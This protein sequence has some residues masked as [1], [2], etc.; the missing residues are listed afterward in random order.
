MKNNKEG[1]LIVFEGLNGSG[2]STQV[3]LLSKR[4]KKEG[5]KVTSIRFPQYNK[6]FYGKLAARYLNGEFGDLYEVNPYL[7]SLTYALDRLSLK[8]NINKWLNEGRI[9]ISDRYVSTSQTSLSAIFKDNNKQIECL[10]WI[11]KMEYDINKIP[12]PDMTIFLKLSSEMSNSLIKKRNIKK[13]IHEKDK[14][15]IKRSEKLLEK[16]SKSSKWLTIKCIKNNKLHS[17]K[18]IHEE[19]FNKIKN[20]I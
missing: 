12:K 4:L 9:V 11:S 15:Y 19:I 2:K 10:K 13:D 8:D 6:S 14:E 16:L 1:K 7:A 20:K 18:S 5:Y 17:I 3:K